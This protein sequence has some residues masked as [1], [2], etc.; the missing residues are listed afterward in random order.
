VWRSLLRFALLGVALFAADRLWWSAGPPAPVEIPAQRVAALR[1]ELARTLGRAPTREEIDRSLRPEVDDALLL[2]E[3]LSRGYERDD[4]VVYRRLVQNLR[5]AGASE[6]QDDDALFEQALALGM[7]ETDVVARRRMIQRLRLDLEASASAEAPDDDALH[8]AYEREPGRFRAPA[9]TRLTQ[10]FFQR[11][12]EDRARRRLAQLEGDGTPPG[13]AAATG[14]PFLHPAEQPLQSRRE[15]ADRFGIAF[16][17]GADAAPL[18]AWSGPIA[19]AYGL[20]LVWVHEREPERA[21]SFEE[22]RESL[23]HEV[24]AERRRAALEEAL[25]ALR[26]DVA[27]VVATPEPAP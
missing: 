11:D 10:L 23:V 22:V 26:R 27:V 1:D 17:E 18:A 16:A 13:A 12:H 3:A 19:S 4:P 25:A 2:R 6:E 21:R 7:H 20:H 9:R 15:L 8:A 24:R 5:F 14:E